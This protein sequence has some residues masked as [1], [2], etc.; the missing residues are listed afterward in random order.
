MR[1]L[2]LLFLLPFF[3]VGQTTYNIAGVQLQG[4]L[5]S[6][7]SIKTINGSNLLGSG[8]ISIVGLP[9]V[10]TDQLA[11]E[12][13]GSPIKAETVG[14]KLGYSNVST[15]LVDGQI[16]YTAAYLPNAQT[17]TGI[18]LYVRV[19]GVYTGDNNNRIGLY[20]YS[21]G[22]LT[23]VASSANSATLWTSAA[24]AVQTIP[25]SVPYVATAGVY[26]VGFVYNNSVQTTAPALASGVALSN[27][28]MASTVWGF[29]NSAKLYGTS[30]GTDLPASINMTAITASVIPSWVALY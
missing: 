21:G 17:L 10:A 22:V 25:F 30:S 20:S 29:T 11:M 26:V 28:V 18:K 16:K 12:A 7:T 8:D 24:N 6:G 2:I 4:G 15:A 14:Q 5:T 3:S 23:L 9:S 13:L 27:L 19:L 1:D